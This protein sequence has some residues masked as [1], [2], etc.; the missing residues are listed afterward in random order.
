[1]LRNFQVEGRCGGSEV[2][3]ENTVF[4]DELCSLLLLQ[5][6]SVTRRGTQNNTL[7]LSLRFQ[8]P[9]ACMNGVAV[10]S[11]KCPPH[12]WDLHSNLH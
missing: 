7:L 5:D 11:S 1:M 12:R 10:R 2:P 6:V 3:A 9:G 8:S 4:R